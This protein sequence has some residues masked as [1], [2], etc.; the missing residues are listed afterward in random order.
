LQNR[1]KSH[2]VAAA[3]RPH[4]SRH[5]I[6][7]YKALR[8]ADGSLRIG[9]VVVDNQFNICGTAFS[10]VFFE[11]HANTLQIAFAEIYNRRRTT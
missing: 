9:F 3:D 10:L 8:E 7:L 5:V 1:G 11:R 2:D 4:H 6:V